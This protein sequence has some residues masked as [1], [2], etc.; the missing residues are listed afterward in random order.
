MKYAQKINKIE[1]I[2]FEKE[3]A[4]DL[5][6]LFPYSYLTLSDGKL[7]ISLKDSG[8]VEENHYIF[9]VGDSERPVVLPKK[10]FKENYKATFNPARF[11]FD[12]YFFNKVK[13]I[14]ASQLT[15]KNIKSILTLAYPF[16]SII[17]G[18]DNR[19]ILQIEF[20]EGKGYY[21]QEGDYLIKD[22]KQLKAMSDSDFSKEYVS[23]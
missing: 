7:N 13:I 21:I 16:G 3:N 22:D 23:A 2:L 5:L 11:G 8:T 9:F 10:L 15:P 6:S 12:S 17:L 20:K 4:L 14:E 1:A 19:L 18:N